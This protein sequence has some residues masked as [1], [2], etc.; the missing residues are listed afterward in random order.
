M[1]SGQSKIVFDPIFENPFSRNC[2]AFPP[3]QFDYQG[4]E[5]LKPDAVFIS[6][7]HD[8]H[9][10]FESLNLLD[11][12]IPIYI[13]SL[14]TEMID[15]IKELGFAKV[16]SLQ[17]NS[18]VQVGEFN[19]TPLEALDQEVDCIF[20]IECGHFSILNVVDSWIAPDTFKE[21]VTKKWDL[22]LWPFQVM[23][24]LE[25]LSPRLSPAFDGKIPIE[26]SEQLERLR[27]RYLVPSSC[28]FQ[29]EDW[30]W[31]NEAF[32]GLS[33]DSFC[34]QLSALS[35]TF[36]VIRLEPGKTLQLS[37]GESKISGSLDWIQASAPESWNHR[38]YF[39]NPQLSTPQTSEIAKKFKAL[40]TSQFEFT[41]NYCKLEL[42][43][44]Y[45]KL[46]LLEEGYFAQ[47]KVWRL[48]LWDHLGRAHSL[49]YLIEGT[50]VR[51]L[52]VIPEDIDWQTEIPVQRL[53][54]ALTQGESLTSIYLRIHDLCYKPETE[55]QIQQTDLFEDPLIR[56]LYEGKFG[57]YQK[58]QL[59]QLKK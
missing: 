53:F 7:Y 58:Y 26:L 42:G 19:V 39:Y 1:Q 13:F 57:T 33:Y 11:R 51:L 23:R 29:F 52:D 55:V 35:N 16:H 25:V 30:S 34:Q 8:D 20:Q 49:D 17:L 36:E 18:S 32:F 21:L 54:G 47:A 2:Y 40:T 12:S 15:W 5:K 31:Y 41:V 37:T 44:E 43:A 50:T 4:I 46:Q 24:E 56:S 59:S 48:L 14:H 10:S 22:V 28:Q 3:V 45:A 6:H 27:T 9:C 38:D